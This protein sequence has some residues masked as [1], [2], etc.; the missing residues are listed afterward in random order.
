MTFNIWVAKWILRQRPKSNYI[1]T[2]RHF[3]DIWTQTDF[4]QNRHNEFLGTRKY[5][6]SFSLDLAG[7]S[8]IAWP[9][10]K[11]LLNTYCLTI[12]YNP[13]KIFAF[14]CTADLTNSVNIFWNLGF[15]LF[16]TKSFNLI[17]KKLNYYN[18]FIS[19]PQKVTFQTL[20]D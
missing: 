14:Y 5:A 7:H 4:C 19:V 9:V 15:V 3:T 12:L 11:R 2:N 6:L 17:G 1:K 18:P 13:M 20:A 10:G 8:W 16:L